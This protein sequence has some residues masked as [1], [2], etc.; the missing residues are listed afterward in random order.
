MDIL[1]S[2]QPA[3]RG[4]KSSLAHQSGTQFRF[5]K[6]AAEEKNAQ[7]SRILQ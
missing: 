4:N 7:L 5:N 2:K 3:S 1:N 6:K